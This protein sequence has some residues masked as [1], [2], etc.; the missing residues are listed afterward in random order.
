MQF[1]LTQVFYNTILFI[2]ALQGALCFQL[3]IIVGYHTEDIDDG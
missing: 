2:I 1:C 3:Q